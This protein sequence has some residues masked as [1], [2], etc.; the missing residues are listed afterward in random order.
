MFPLSSTSEILSYLSEHRINTLNKINKQKPD[1]RAPCTNSRR[2]PEA[3]TAE[4]SCRAKG[5]F[6]HYLGTPSTLSP[7]SHCGF[8][9]VCS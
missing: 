1:H 6:K 7:L 5:K 8:K 2:D 9:E 3:E 4:G